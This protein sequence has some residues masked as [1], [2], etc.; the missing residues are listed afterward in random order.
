VGNREESSSSVDVN[1]YAVVLF[2]GRDIVFTD[3][4]GILKVIP[5]GISVEFVSNCAL[6]FHILGN[7]ECSDILFSNDSH[8]LVVKS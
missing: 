4:V 2:T 5:V 6:F 7:V 1:E 8:I 3:Q